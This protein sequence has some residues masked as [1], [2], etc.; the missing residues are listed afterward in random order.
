MSACCDAA[1]YRKT[2][3]WVRRVR[4][5]FAW[6]LPSVI[7]VVMPKCPACLAAYV[8][9]AT[10]IGLSLA[11]ASCLRWGLLVLCSA[12]LLFLIIFRP[13]R[14]ARYWHIS[15]RKPDHATSNSES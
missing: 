12:S 6:L 14:V 15:K 1:D 3:I 11:T 2:P 8:S 9:L 13:D 5:A 4:E 10:G 7:L